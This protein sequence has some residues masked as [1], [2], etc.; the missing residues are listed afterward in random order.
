M[1]T[2]QLFQIGIKA[3][4]QN[5]KGE[6]LLLAV[7]AWDDNPAH[8]DL[9]GGRMEPGEDFVQTLRRELQEEIGIAYDGPAEHMATVLSNITIPVGDARVPLILMPYRVQLPAD[10]VITLDPNG[11]EQ[12]F[13][14]CTPEV[15]AERLLRK[16]PQEFCNA[17]K[18]L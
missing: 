11:P 13:A 4:A 6:I 16:Y 7:P 15:A 5:E 10:S 2:E 1:A 14:W 3:V 12:E 17:I 8:W 9:P 18:E